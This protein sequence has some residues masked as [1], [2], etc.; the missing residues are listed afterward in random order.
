MRLRLSGLIR[1]R[2]IAGQIV[3]LVLV[4]VGLFSLA[5]H[6]T[7]A[8]FGKRPFRPDQNPFAVA[9]RFAEFARLLDH[10]PPATRPEVVAALHITYPTLDLTLQPRLASLPYSGAFAPP[11]GAESLFAQ[12]HRLLGPDL[13]LFTP[14]LESAQNGTTG[15]HVRE[16][17]VAL[18]D[19]AVVTGLVL[20]IGRPPGRPD[21]VA[22]VTATLGFMILMLTLLL[23]WA[24]RGLTAPLSRFAQ[25]AAGFSLDRDAAP[26]PEKG[27]YEVRTAARAFNRMQARIRRMVEDRT[28]MLAA[29]SHDLRT[30]ITRLRLRAEFIEDETTRAQMLR[31]LDQMSAMIHAALS[32]LRDG[33]SAEARSLVD[34]ASVLQ[35]ICDEFTDVGHTVGY[36]GPDHLLAAVRADEVNR[37][38]VN[39][40]ENA[41]KFGTCAVVRLRPIASE[42]VEIDVVDDG[43]GIPDPDKDAMLQPFARGDVA[44]GMNGPSGFGLGLSIARAVAE[45]HGGE[46]TLHDAQPSGLIARL[47]LPIGSGQDERAA[48][49]PPSPAVR[50]KQPAPAI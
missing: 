24:T 33:Q 50:K 42:S 26:L 19:G 31:D 36:E 35:T 40:V 34:L 45:A 43:P 15:R 23:W 2:T 17:A 27:S 28:R 20:P 38:V 32:Y 41:V 6:A 39:L 22:I 13:Q 44:R 30:P 49:E 10:L 14:A 25:A 48:P 18:R 11:P 12:L 3:L 5:L 16:V 37:A 21:P 29:V 9:D 46:L 7:S 4:S 47:R 8:L 1:P